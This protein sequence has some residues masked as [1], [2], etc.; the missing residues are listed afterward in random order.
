MVDHLR[1]VFFQN[2]EILSL[3]AKYGL[4]CC[5]SDRNRDH[6]E[7]RIDSYHVA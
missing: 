3:K 4:T 1:F 2:T 5:V 7:P 6:N